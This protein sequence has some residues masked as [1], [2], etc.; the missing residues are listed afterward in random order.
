MNG[1]N[2]MNE[3][4]LSLSTDLTLEWDDIIETDSIA[5]YEHTDSISDAL[6][7]SLSNFACVDIEYISAITGKDY[8]TIINALRGSIFQNPET[9]D[10]C[11]YKGWETAEE[12]LSGNLSH[13]LNVAKDAND[14]YL[15]I[16]QSNVDA[17]EKNLPSALSAKDIYIT[18]GSPW[19]PTD[20]IDAFVTHILKID[21]TKYRGYKHTIHDEYT[22][23]WELPEKRV[24]TRFM[25]TGNSFGTPRM[26]ALTI[27]ETTLNMQTAIVMDEIES[28]HT[29]SGKKRIIN[30]AETLVAVEKQELMIQ[31]FKRWVWS[32]KTRRN[33]LKKIFEE[34]YSSMKRRVFD[35]SF[36]TFPTMNPDITLHP[37]QKNAVAR[38]IFSSNTLLAHDVGAGKTFIMITAGMELKRMKLS[39]KN[40]YVVPNSITGQWGSLFHKLY[41]ESK[42]FCITP[43]DFTLE[44][45]ISVLKKIRDED[46]DAIIMPYSCFEQIPISIECMIQELIDEDKKIEKILKDSNEPSPR[47][48]NRRKAIKKSI[49]EL[50][51]KSDSKNGVFF[52][53]LGITRLFVDEAHNFKNLPI[54]TRTNNALGINS[55]GSKKCVDMMKKVHIVQRNNNGGGVIMA[56]GTPITNSITDAYTMQMYLQSGELAVLD[57]NSF[58]GW[59]GMFA[60]RVTEFEIDVDTSNFRMVTRFSKFHNLPELTVLLSS[61]A[62][63]HSVDPSV[64]LPDFNG[65]KDIVIPR[66]DEFREYLKTISER[67]DEVRNGNV[68][69]KTDNMLKITTDGRK[70]ALDLRLVVP[71]AT[72]TLNSKVAKCAQT[73]FNIYTQTHDSKSIQIIFCD[74]STP[75]DSFNIYDETKRLLIEKGID[76]KEIVFI[77]DADSEAKRNVLFEKL[78]EGNIRIIIGSTFKL[79]LGVNIQDKLIALHHLDIPWR[80]ADMTQREGRILRQGNKNKEVFIYRY[81]TEGSFDAYSWQL[82]ETKQRFITD[83]LMGSLSERNGNN[84]EDTV[85]NYAEVKALAIGNPLIK[86][87]VEISNKLARYKTLQKK[88]IETKIM[89]EQER[90]TLPSRIEHQRVIVDCCMD[91]ITYISSSMRKCSKNDTD[92]LLSVLSE[93]VKNHVFMDTEKYIGEYQ[94]FRISIPKNMSKHKPAVWVRRYGEYFVE[95]G[96]SPKNYIARIDDFLSKLQ[97]HYNKIK[98]YLDDLERKYADIQADIDRCTDYTEDIALLTAELM[99]ID[100]NLGVDVYE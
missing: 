74:T 10:E 47:L 11:E 73:V 48:T 66:T 90:E 23:S 58:D 62:D 42:V 15:G 79:G 26:D 100:K 91:D 41:P 21:T 75:K 7:L 14:E 3:N 16:F 13:K 27:L 33:R 25:S 35:G 96:N 45:R 51:M 61:I 2:I 63:F 86:E 32:D 69:L 49:S 93:G 70:A 72:F 87:R 95:L 81:I 9:W 5:E 64:E 98:S 85:L 39:K 40:L 43:K 77:H 36:L 54:K 6:I 65:Y 19:I 20:I 97:D 83:L 4:T 18:L 44:K 99:E 28:E 37:Y 89:L 30:E 84:I 1:V 80:P 94:G 78:R 8:A 56:T 53:D 31:E 76:S 55:V 71:D 60:E 88:S 24:F 50:R 38:I 46:F 92:A 57:L 22:G 12:Y 34:K 68:D 17:L 29:K 82:L 59:V 52:D 67:A